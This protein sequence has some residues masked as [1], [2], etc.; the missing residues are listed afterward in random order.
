L[1]PKRGFV[2]KIEVWHVWD[3]SSNVTQGAVEQVKFFLRNSALTSQELL[4]LGAT[5]FGNQTMQIVH[6]S[7]HIW[8]NAC[9]SP[10]P[11]VRV[12]EF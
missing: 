1:L 4:R 5:H 8:S 3:A 11:K 9:R 6:V 12:A 7:S 2:K 10:R